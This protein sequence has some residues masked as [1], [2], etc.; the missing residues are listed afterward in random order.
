MPRF[1]LVMVI[2]QLVFKAGRNRDRADL[3]GLRASELDLVV[4]DMA[5]FEVLGLA[6]SCARSEAYLSDHGRMAVLPFGLNRPG[7]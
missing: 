6:P 4:P 1:H 2:T 5:H 3:A 7:F